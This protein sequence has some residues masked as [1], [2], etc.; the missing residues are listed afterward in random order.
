[1][2]PAPRAVSHFGLA[3][4]EARAIPAPR[5]PAAT[6]PAKLPQPQVQPRR[7][8]VVRLWL[9]LTALWRN[10]RAGKY[11]PRAE[12]PARQFLSP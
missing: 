5:P 11:N 12:H 6:I 1:M 8:V 4:M 9:P 7:R 3:A 10:S 2:T